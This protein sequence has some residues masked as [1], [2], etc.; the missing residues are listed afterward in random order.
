M[1]DEMKETDK[2]KFE[3]YYKE[4]YSICFN[5]LTDIKSLLDEISNRIAEAQRD[6]EDIYIR[7]ESDKEKLIFLSDRKDIL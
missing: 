2:N 3:N 7:A 6:V 1:G 5:T 4:M